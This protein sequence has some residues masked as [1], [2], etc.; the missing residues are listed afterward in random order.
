MPCIGSL[1]AGWSPGGCTTYDVE[2]P[3]NGSALVNEI[4]VA[5]GFK[6]R[7]D[8]AKELARLSEG[9]EKL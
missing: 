4:S 2:L 8:V 7:E 3:E 1:P 6:T 5:I 9:F